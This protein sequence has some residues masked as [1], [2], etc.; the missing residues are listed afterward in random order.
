MI[1]GV[2]LHVVGMARIARALGSR[3]RSFEERVYTAAERAACAQRAD[4]VQA[5]AARF[6][7]KAAF[8]EALGVA[9]ERGVSLRQVE[10]VRKLGG[11]PALRVVGAA[12]KHARRKR[13]RRSYVTLTHGPRLAAAVVVLEV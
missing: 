13:V 4:R 6:A 2:A 9:S 12:L 10:V 11:R 8:C 7:A 3:D 1:L 5:L